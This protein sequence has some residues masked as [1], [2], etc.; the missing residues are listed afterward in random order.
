MAIFLLRPPGPTFGLE[1]LVFSVNISLNCLSINNNHDK[2]FKISNEA[3][4]SKNVL[5]NILEN[6][7]IFKVTK[8]KSCLLFKI[9][10]ITNIR[11]GG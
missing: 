8:F 3:A 7:L 10:S 9:L 11:P 1:V 4:S 2:R 6:I 5:T